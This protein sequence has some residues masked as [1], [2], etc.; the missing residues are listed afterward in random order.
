MVS[1]SPKKKSFGFSMKEK[2]SASS[3]LKTKGWTFQTK[4][5][6]WNFLKKKGYT[7]SATWVATTS[8]GDAFS[9]PPP[10]S[11]GES[12]CLSTVTKADCARHQR[13]T[14]RRSSSTKPWF[15]PRLPSTTHNLLSDNSHSEEASRQR[16]QQPSH[17][18]TTTSHDGRHCE[19]EW[20][21]C[22]QSH[23]RHWHYA[24]SPLHTDTLRHCQ[25]RA[26]TQPFP[27]ASSPPL[28][29]LIAKPP[30]LP[31]LVTPSTVITFI[32]SD[33]ITVVNRC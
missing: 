16:Q 2:A 15:F 14:D 7:F 30:S 29:G 31:R 18:V 17:N 3:T 27:T 13:T 5:K 26:I 11:K 23:H 12:F 19:E 1:S 33:D 22:M 6:A 28:T 20:R 8:I 9:S 4:K 24:Q 25:R 32:H 21:H 10:S